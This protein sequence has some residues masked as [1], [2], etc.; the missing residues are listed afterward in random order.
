MPKGLKRFQQS[1]QSHVVTFGCYRCRP[2][3]ISDASKQTFENALE[4]VRRSFNL[5]VY[6][7]VIM[8]DHVHLLL[9]EPQ[10]QL[11]ADALKSLKQGVSRRLIGE[12]EHF[13]EKRYYDLNIRTESQFTEKLGYIHRNPMKGG[14]CEHPEEWEWSS[15]RHYALGVKGRV[16]IESAWTAWERAANPLK[17]TE[18]LNGPPNG[19]YPSQSKPTPPSSPKQ[20]GAVLPGE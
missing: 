5:C 17:P 20:R 14:L 16:E 2:L 3:F 11:L 7:Y 15:S 18:G 12:A 1:G 4:R 10:H 19:S 8:P 6:G 9:G 13:W